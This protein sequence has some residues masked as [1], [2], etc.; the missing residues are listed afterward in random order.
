MAFRRLGK[1]GFTLV[2]LLVVIA[3][4][5]ILISLL[6]PAVQAAR[7]SARR[8][9]CTNHL[10]QLSL[11]TLNHVD[12]NGHYPTGGR[13]GPWVGEADRGFGRRQ[14]GGWIFNL[15]PYIEQN[16]IRQLD[17]GTTGQA[18][19]DALNRRDATA[20]P[21][22]NCPSRRSAIPLP[23]LNSANFNGNRSEL[24][25]RADYAV[26]CGDPIGVELDWP[27]P[28]T[29]AEGDDPDRHWA[30]HPGYNGVSSA[31]SLVRLAQVTD[32]TSNTYMIGERY[33]QPEHYFTGQSHSDDWSMY[34][35]AGDDLIRTTYRNVKT[36]VGWTP[37][38]DRRGLGLHTHFGSSHAGGCNFALCDGSVRVVSYGIDAVTHQRSGNR[39]DGQPVDGSRL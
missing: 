26:S 2:E 8:A 30:P 24:H 10:K 6:L 32:G 33:I 39:Q 9:Q 18:R 21:I 4:I 20:L 34:R 29:F 27:W 5:G 23:N 36:D 22:C 1:R 15:L 28:S 38:Q 17:S 7:E 12:V 37:L 3:I 14:P 13:P 11:A 25:A 35:S 19:I 31:F 16:S